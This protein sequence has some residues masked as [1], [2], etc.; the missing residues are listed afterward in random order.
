MLTASARNS[1]PGVRYSGNPRLFLR[2]LGPTFR[3]V[4]YSGSPWLFSTV[5]L[6][7]RQFGLD[8][9]SAGIADSRNSGPKPMLTTG[10]VFSQC[11]QARLQA[12][13]LN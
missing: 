10:Y 5:T 2:F 6:W 1:E 4:C 8:I 11:R 9:A 12:S 3:C 7:F 13:I